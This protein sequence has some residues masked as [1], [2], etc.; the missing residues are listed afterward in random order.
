MG[1]G[2]GVV[3]VLALQVDLNNY[4]KRKRQHSKTFYK[5]GKNMM[6]FGG[7]LWQQCSS[8]PLLMSVGDS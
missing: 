4:I 2:G 7:L 3:H 1:G 6:C 5:S 8:L